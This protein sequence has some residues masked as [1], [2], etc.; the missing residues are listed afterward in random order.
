MSSVTILIL[1]QM[2][3]A[4]LHFKRKSILDNLIDGKSKVNEILKVW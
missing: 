2:P 3:N 1:E 4:T